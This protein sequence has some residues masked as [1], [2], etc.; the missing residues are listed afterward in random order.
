[1]DGYWESVNK[2]KNVFQQHP[3]SCEILK[4]YPSPVCE[5]WSKKIVAGKI[6][7]KKIRLCRF[8]QLTR[9]IEFCRCHIDK[10]CSLENWLMSQH[11]LTLTTNQIKVKFTNIHWHY[12]QKIRDAQ[13]CPHK[14]RLFHCFLP[15]TI[16]AFL[17]F[18]NLNADFL[19][20]V[21]KCGSEQFFMAWLCHEYTHTH[22]Y[23]RHLSLSVA[24]W[25]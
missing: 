3:V 9:T 5:S 11:E 12:P 15:L 21:K 25:A 1:M 16:R 6:G 14:L 7:A 19:S 20:F 13:N 17:S 22:T 24:D 8:L 23:H 2:I 4:S 10:K 18:G